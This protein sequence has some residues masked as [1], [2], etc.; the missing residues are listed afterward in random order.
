M[1]TS[2]RCSSVLRRWL[3]TAALA[4]VAALAQYHYYNVTGGS[5]TILQNYRSPNTP[6]GIYDAVH[7]E[8]V[9]SSDGGS[10]Y[11]YGGFTHQNQVNG[12]PMTLLQYV[13]WPAS[14]GFAPYSQQIPTFAGTNMVWYPQIGEGSCCAIKGY[15]P[16]FTTNLWTREAVRYWA[17]SDGTPHL[18][19]QGM[20]MKEAVSGNWYH[21]GTFMYP[22]AVTG[23]TGMSG[24]QENFSGY[25]GSYIVDHGP[26]YY[27]LNGHWQSAS[28]VSYTSSGYVSLINS[29]AATESQ[30]ANSSLGNNVPRTLTMT[31]PSAPGFDPIVVSSA[32]AAVLNSQ[33]LVQWQL[34]LSSSPQLAYLVEVFNNSAYSG[35]PAV[36]FYQAE[37][38]TRQKL[39]AIPGISTPF[40]RLTIS[41]IFWNTNAPVLITPTAASLSPATTVS[42][43]GTGL[44]YRYYESTNGD[45]TALPDF[46]QLAP[47]YEG[48][49]NLTDVTPRRQR[50]DYGFS[51]SGYL[52]VPVDGLY[53]FTIHSGD[54]SRMTIDGSTV[55]QFDGLHDSSQFMAGGAALAAGR[56]AFSLQFFKG[57]ANP[58][59]TTAYTDGLGVAW[60]GPGL[61]RADIP[62]TAYSRTP[63]AAEPSIS[64]TVPSGPVGDLAPGFQASVNANGNTVNTVQ[65][66]LTE[67]SSY[68]PRPSQG[69]DY[70]AG[71]VTA[72]PYSFNSLIWAAPTNQVRARVF[73]NG[74]R[75]IDSAPVVFTSTNAPTGKWYWTPLEMH[76][77]PSAGSVQGTSLALLGDGMNLLSRVVTGDCVLIGR[78][79]GITPNVAGPDG[80]SPSSSWRA[81]I[82]LR[83]TTNTTIGQPLGD[84]GATRFAAL[85][86]SVGGGSY[87]ENDT[88]RNGNGDA[89]AWSGNLGANNWFKLQRA[90]NTFTSFVST[91]GANWNQANSVTLTNFG[92]AIYAGFFTHAEQSLNPNLHWG[93]LD[94]FNLLGT[95]VAGPAG[96]WV[97][98]PTNLVVAG[99]SA[100]FS[101]SVIGPTPTG[102]QWQFN[103]VNLPGATNASLSIPTVSAANAGN[104][105]IVANSITSAPGVL[106][107][108]LPA[109]SAVWTNRSGGSWPVGANWSPGQAAGGTDA[110]ADFSTLNLS[111]N[112]T[113][114]LDGARTAGTLAF[115]DQN[116]A[117]KH[118]WTI[119]PGSGGTLTLGTSA[120]AP[121]IA[122]LGGSNTL[123]V[124]VAGTQGLLKTGTGYL[125]L[126]TSATFSGT[127][128]VGA[129]T[130]E[131]RAKSGDVPYVISPGATLKVGYS[132]GGG[133]ANT[134]L[135]LAGN[136][137]GSAAGLCLQGGTSYNVD[138]GLTINSAPATIHQY[139]SGLAGIGTFDINVNPGL[140]TTAAASGSAL[141][142]NIQLISFGYGMVV[143]TDAGSSNAAGDLTVNGPLNVT[144]LGLYKRG[145]GSLRLNGQATSANTAVNLQG[146]SI[147]CGAA[148]CLGTKASVPITGG[149]W[150]YLNGW[151]QSI[152]SLNVGSGC[153]L[154]FG[155]PATLSVASAP[156]LAGALQMTFAKGAARSNSTLVVSSGTLGLGGTLT[157]SLTGTNP[158]AGGDTLTLFS[159]PAYS[160]RFASL[161]LPTLPAGLA[162]VTSNL[163][164]NGTLSITTNSVVCYEPFGP[165][166]GA[167]AALLSAAPTGAGFAGPW[168][169]STAAAGSTSYY[170]RMA[171]PGRFTNGW[172]A[173]V[174]FPAP[175][176]GRAQ[177]NDTA[178]SWTTLTRPLS[179]PLNFSAPGV[180]YLGFLLLDNGNNN[181]SDQVFLGSSASGMRIY[182]GHGYGGQLIAVGNSTTLPWQLSASAGL[183]TGQ[184][185]GCS[186]TQ[187]LYF[188]ARLA[189][190]GA[191]HTTIQIRHYL[192][193]PVAQ[194]GATVENDANAV[195]WE[196]SYT[197]TVSGTF[198]QLG[199]SGGGQNSVPEISEIR[200]A[201]NWTDI[202]GTVPVPLAILTQP[203][204]AA[205][206]NYNG[207]LVN[208]AVA[209]EG[210]STLGYQW[211]SGPNPIAG[212]T[213]AGF[214]ATTLPG[215]TNYF[216][217]VT[218]ASGS[219]TSAT[220]QLTGW[221]FPPPTGSFAVNFHQVGPDGLF[222]GQG[223]YAD[224]GGN[225]NWNPLPA[226]STNGAT[227]QPA[228]SSA[229][230]PTLVTASLSASGSSSYYAIPS[231]GA[232]CFLLGAYAYQSLSPYT[233]ALSFN[234]VPPGAYWLYC[235]AQDGATGGRGGTF[236]LT[237]G[238]GSADRGL[239]SAINAPG[240]DCTLVEGV[241]YVLFTNVVPDATGRIALSETPVT[242]SPTEV[243]FNG[244]QLVWAAAA[245]VI[246]TQ[247]VAQIIPQGATAQ[248]IV[249]A[250]GAPTPQFRWMKSN[251]PL[252]DGTTGTG[253]V[254]AGSLTNV[255]TLTNAQPGDSG[256]YTVGITNPAGGV[257]SAP[258][259]LLVV[260]PAS[261][262]TAPLL[263]ATNPGGR[264]ALA[265]AALPGYRYLLQRAT[266]LTPPAIW[267][268]LSNAAPAASGYLILLADPATNPAA[269]YRAGVTNQ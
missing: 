88:M 122:A 6:P 159:A 177:L 98:P 134:A 45:W 83:G 215:I 87:Y 66:F 1:I 51:Y 204:P 105:T 43:T 16:Q 119:S 61:A 112:P 264:F 220:V 21:V 146:G 35:T 227:T 207:N 243:D 189:P 233:L 178:S 195:A 188:A 149:G 249:S 80:V 95:N 181:Y 152:S 252:T 262:A 89:N 52:T 126:A 258:A 164:V 118:N 251:Q 50:T 248:F 167:Q 263:T 229:G 144:S 226:I 64:L 142:P 163:T 200:L 33:L 19:Y 44:N 136:G 36:S 39:L 241:N 128:T 57:A 96:V 148:N 175:S 10:G 69:V 56:H 72:A 76:D 28:Q 154:S 203:Q 225:T 156:V 182:L 78:V 187:L 247:P 97:N 124:T 216:V 240:N 38:E 155:A 53:A 244:A 162:W 102:Y 201:T 70:F 198:D 62:A 103:G 168:V 9:N 11:F 40:V 15:W 132:T 140:Y 166:G 75:S 4:P 236:S 267:T 68:Y 242:Q 231:P 199:L 208:Y 121:A 71:S 46:T 100:S 147:N 74:S 125:A 108:S 123:N 82:I 221:P 238:S 2:P 176:G 17:P 219:V 5:D 85:F 99:L 137:V 141:D 114:T 8:Y 30:V 90:G 54:G 101:A 13:C 32:T 48:A 191:G 259:Q 234:N 169:Q 269:F 174:A 25:S 63:A 254:V 23:V 212:A 20:W 186:G 94:N 86:T 165:T 235:Y 205:T 184:M 218:N 211:F 130:L 84:G 107:L 77:Y 117:G 217:V 224:A 65:Y 55:I 7:E 133:Y 106:L 230:A 135:T 93:T 153:G 111:L 173:G 213:N 232:T 139:G 246:T 206:T 160:G 172:P 145:A 158:P 22:F 171:D 245:P 257:V 256:T 131:V 197:A 73:Y 115:D 228:V 193:D 255:L 104:Y 180:C 237:A 109:G 239:T 223:A 183:P 79:T 260:P 18:G 31:Q 27:H 34:P 222:H 116:P 157:I 194:T 190:D 150:L 81:G 37:P 265:L 60:E 113:V 143:T 67:Y 91:D 24:W 266:N 110:V 210:T 202:A 253:S 151:S 192:F 41:D 26:G 42:G 196:A 170:E 185:P 3:A 179:N 29:G 47:V 209:A 138:G 12:T 214:S 58:V 59:N 161:S 250:S 120:G 14:G 49:V 261:S 129:G 268:T 92:T 127:A